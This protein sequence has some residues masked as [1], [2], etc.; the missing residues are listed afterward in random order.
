MRQ[1][2]KFLQ[3]AIAAHRAFEAATAT[4][5]QLSREGR[6]DSPEWLAALTRQ[7]QALA[8]WSAL[9]SKYGDFDA[10]EKHP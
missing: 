6:V 3:E 10:D 2:E 8:E 1:R 9:P 4:L 7:Q 5:R